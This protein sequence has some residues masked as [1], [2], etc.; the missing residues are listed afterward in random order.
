MS[1]ETR[2]IDFALEERVRINREREMTRAL[3]PPHPSTA[4]ILEQQIKVGD[5]DID[6]L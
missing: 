2:L 3:P 5:G 4:L 1:Q 6:S